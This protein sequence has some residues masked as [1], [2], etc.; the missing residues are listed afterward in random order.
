M[1][2]D[3]LTGSTT[4]QAM[5]EGATN[6]VSIKGNKKDSTP[7]VEVVADISA[8]I[9]KSKSV[10]TGYN[11]AEEKVKA[12][13][14]SIITTAE[15]E[16]HEGKDAG[17]LV[18]FKPVDVNDAKYLSLYIKGNIFQRQG[19]DHYASIQVKD[20]DGKQYIMLELCKEGKYGNAKGKPITKSSEIRKGTTLKMPLAEDLK[21]VQRL[22]IVFVGET[23]VDAGL[24]MKDIKLIK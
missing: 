15:I 12:I 8:A 4:V 24:T 10:P 20:E 9:E 13:K 22:E 18:E 5:I 14:G 17:F 16:G 11:G 1:A 3:T 19:W 23:E 7:K 21:T 6:T 2:V